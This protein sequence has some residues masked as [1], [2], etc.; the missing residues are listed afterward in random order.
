MKYSFKRKKTGILAFLIVPLFIA[1]RCRGAI[2]FCRNLGIQEDPSLNST[3]PDGHLS[4]HKPPPHQTLP[5]KH[6]H[7]PCTI[8]Y[9]TAQTLRRPN[10]VLEVGA[11]AALQAHLLSSQWGTTTLENCKSL[12]HDVNLDTFT[13]KG[14]ADEWGPRHPTTDKLQRGLK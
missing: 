4:N 7:I 11:C 6:P 3:S 1:T 2:Q 5:V 14:F 12:K 8:P 9:V 10:Q 13:F